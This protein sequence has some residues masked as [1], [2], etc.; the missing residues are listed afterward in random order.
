MLQ[1]GGLHLFAQA[2]V[3]LAMS[4]FRAAPPFVEATA[5]DAEDAAHPGNPEGGLML[6]NEG[7]LHGARRA[8]HAA[9][10]FKMSRPYRSSAFFFVTA[11]IP[12]ELDRPAPGPLGLRLK[13]PP[14]Q[15]V[16]A[17]PEFLGGLGHGAIRRQG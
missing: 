8:K 9:A 14:V 12:L 7:V 3:F 5:G 10:F 13:D 11:S 16:L 4:T 15:G 1:E 6:L 17:Q 2:A